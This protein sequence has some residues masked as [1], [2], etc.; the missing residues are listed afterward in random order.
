MA[1]P[2]PRGH[3][4]LRWVTVLALIGGGI[5][6]AI[7]GEVAYCVPGLILMVVELVASL[8]LGLRRE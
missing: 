8:V 1:K 5:A 3:H 2:V 6:T 7:T 4:L